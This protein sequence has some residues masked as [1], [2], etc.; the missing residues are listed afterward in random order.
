M[1]RFFDYSD[2][3]RI[4]LEAVVIFCF[5]TLVGLTLQHQLVSDLLS[6]KLTAPA[7][8]KSAT[9]P[10]PASYPQPLPFAELQPQLQ[11]GALLLDAR[12]DELYREGHIPGSLSRPL[13]EVDRWLP[14][15]RQHYPLNTP[16]I[17]YCNGYGCPDSF[18]LAVR[19]LEQGYEKVMVFEGGFPEW[20]DA[21]LPV[22][23][24]E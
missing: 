18:D 12:I 2:L 14:R 10:E 4:I 23:T 9:S 3:P 16:I 13:A 20:R 21:G 5:G 19:L 22:Q 6:G 17:T 15:F 1:N 8:S 7:V 11:Q 24:E